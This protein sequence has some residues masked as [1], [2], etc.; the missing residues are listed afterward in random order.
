[1]SRVISINGEIVPPERSHVSVLD[2]GFLYGDGVFESLRVYAG[3]P[4]ALSDHVARLARSAA[5][6]KI[7]LP[8]PIDAISREILAA[9][10]AS[11]ESSEG[12]RRAS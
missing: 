5:T 11:R 3:R 4:F 1:M 9:I 2:R 12:V 7:T 8:V 10:A 6:L